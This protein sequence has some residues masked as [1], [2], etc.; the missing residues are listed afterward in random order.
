MKEFIKKNIF[1]IIFLFCF[2]VF[3]GITRIL[4][5]PIG[6]TV[7][8]NFLTFFTEM[9]SFLPAMFIL[10]GLFDVWV[11]RKIVERHI[12]NESGIKGMLWVILFATL[13]AGPLYGAFPVAVM[14]YKKGASV[15]NVFIYLGAF[16][17]YKIPM[18]TFEIT[19]LGLKFSLLRT[20]FSLPV[21]IAIGY[22]MNYV[23]KKIKLTV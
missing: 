17:A 7:E 23:S 5:F 3:T 16:S 20:I 15:K 22:F 21:F 8:K 4:N 6:K 9:I 11:P 13:Q 10:I 18:L 12:G 14:L 19:F 2:L 1:D